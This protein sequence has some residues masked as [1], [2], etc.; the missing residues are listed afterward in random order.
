MCVLAE[1]LNAHALR[2]AFRLNNTMEHE[3]SVLILGCLECY[4]PR[5]RSPTVLRAHLKWVLPLATFIDVVVLSYP[6]E[7]EAIW[8]PVWNQAVRYVLGNSLL[9]Q[10][11]VLVWQGL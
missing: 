5:T 2:G 1:F 9:L 6:G 4:V 7:N 3:G 10:D 11:R 8:A